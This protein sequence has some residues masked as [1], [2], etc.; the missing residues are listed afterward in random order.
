MSMIFGILPELPVSP[1]QR[2]RLT[3]TTLKALSSRGTHSLFGPYAS[4]SDHLVSNFQPLVNDREGLAQLLFINAQRRIGKER[5]PADESIEPLF[6][7]ESSQCS[8]FFGRVIER[9][10]GLAGLA[11]A[12]QFDDAEQAD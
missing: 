6:A 1:Q 7:E 11:A 9:S 2:S 5:V 4:I 3:P 10:H 8:H 12:D